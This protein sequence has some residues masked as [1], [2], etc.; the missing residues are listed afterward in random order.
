MEKGRLFELRRRTFDT[1]H[2]RGIEF[3][4][5]EA[6]TIIN[7]VPGN[8]LPFN[9]TINP[10]RGCSHGCHG[11]FARVTHTYMDLDPARD[12][13]TKIVVKVNAP[14]LLD[15]ELASP[16][17]CGEPIA[18]GTSTD[19][20]QRAEGKY[21]LM[22]RI[23][24]ALTKYRN[25]FSIL[26]RSPL[27]LRDLD[28]LVDAAK[29][30]DVGTALSVPTLDG[31]VW[32]HSEPGT[33]HPRKRM[34]AVRKLNENGIPCGVM[35]A[36]I[37]PGISD[38][39]DQ[40]MDVVKAAVDAGATFITPIM[41][42]LRPVVREEYMS[43]LGDAY[44]GL[45]K[46]YE[47]MYS[48]GAYGPK[49][50]RRRVSRRVAG[51]VQAAGGTRDVPRRTGH[52]EP[53]PPVDRD[54][55]IATPLIRCMRGPS[56]VSQR[57]LERRAPP[58]HPAR[59]FTGSPVGRPCEGEVAWQSVRR[60]RSSGVGAPAAPSASRSPATTTR[61]P[62]PGLVPGRDVNGRSAFSVCPCSR[63]SRRSRRPPTS[64][65]SRSPTTRSPTWEPSSR[66]VI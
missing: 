23:I 26:T 27:I 12:W 56:P 47:E 25:G 65:S 54:Q 8:Y 36:P 35:V 30:T 28:L 2:F 61:S 7:K 49:E 58:F 53:K 3:I 32:R 50:A 1:P 34:D 57:E 20:Y 51:L 6:K 40:F 52:P 16:R 45:V 21:E 44:P 4:E 14:E 38:R 43:W 5:A 24:K 17:W 46:R 41:L 64:C 9:W 42:H 63:T 37:L 66:R 39:P 10:Y 11:C 62:P 60:C 59:L 13:Q 55:A 33:P 19:P 31:D 15:R 48:G 29:V 22:S 18:M